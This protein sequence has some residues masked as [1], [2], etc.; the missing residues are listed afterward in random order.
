MADLVKQAP[1]L[2][3]ALQVRSPGRP[4]ERSSEPL[5]SFAANRWAAILPFR[6]PRQQPRAP[7]SRPVPASTGVRGGLYPAAPAGCATVGRSRRL[8]LGGRAVPETPIRKV[9]RATT[10]A[11]PALVDRASVSHAICAWVTRADLTNGAGGCATQQQV[12][13]WGR[14]HE[15]SPRTVASPVVP[16]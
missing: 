5:T 2:E 14:M 16:A 7:R 4:G 6:T 9:A 10:R 1:Y 11:R 12:H 13:P 8:A 15:L 3:G